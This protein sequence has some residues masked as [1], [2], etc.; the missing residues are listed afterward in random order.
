[1]IEFKNIFLRNLVSFK[2]CFLQDSEGHEMPLSVFLKSGQSKGFLSYIKNHDSIIDD[3]PLKEKGF[4]LLEVM[5]AVTIMAI[6]FT[7]VLSVHS[8]TVS[9]NIASNFHTKAP[10]LAKKII[11]EWRSD[12]IVNGYTDTIEINLDDFPLFN[13]RLNTR[14]IDSDFLF[15]EKNNNHI[16][17]LICNILYN[18][19]EYEYTT[20][21]F[22]LIIP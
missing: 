10:L 5:V 3:A 18:D 11:S 19:G 21:S 7:A 4:T 12:I 15:S 20:K 1:M 2:D 9:M 14:K 22:E 8:Q 13:Y 16:V 6:A 17:E